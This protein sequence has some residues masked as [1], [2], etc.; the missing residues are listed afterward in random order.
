MGSSGLLH[1]HTRHQHINTFGFWGGHSIAMTAACHV[2]AG[3]AVVYCL[4]ITTGLWHVA[5]GIL[6]LILQKNVLV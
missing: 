3:V 2:P 4:L 1:F 5:C 6:N